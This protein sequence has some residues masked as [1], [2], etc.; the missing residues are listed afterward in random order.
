M[1]LLIFA[2]SLRTDSC[3][4]KFAREALRLSK[5]AGAEGEFIDLRD[6]PMPVYDGD[7]Q[8]SLGIPESTAKLGQK[9]L[10]ADG[11]IISTPEYNAGIPGILKNAVDWLSREKTVS[12]AGKHLLLLAASPGAVGG[13]R[14]LWHSRQPFEM[15]GTHVFPNM[16]G[17]PDAYNAFDIQGRLKDEKT[18]ERLQD[19]LN[20][21]IKHVRKQLT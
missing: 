2:G 3:N 6:Y 10:A 5:E 12:L 14:S 8:D 19:I 11:L 1:K 18:I 4:K 13:M 16:M 7:I 20:Q 21:F 9:I 15:L 17:L